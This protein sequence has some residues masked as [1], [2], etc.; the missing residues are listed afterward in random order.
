[1]MYYPSLGGLSF[2]AALPS[3]GS[4]SL[5]VASA[6][7]SVDVAFLSVA[8]RAFLRCYFS[9]RRLVGFPSLQLFLPS[10]SS[11]YPSLRLFFPSLLLF[12][13][14]FGGFPSLQL[15][16]PSVSSLFPSLRGLSVT[17]ALLLSATIN[18]TGTIYKPS[19]K[20]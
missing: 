19:Y 10:V 15:F 4:L 11:L 14:S 7:L 3:V 12:Y 1:M 9:F 17:S 5:S 13:P 8:W 6:V 20:I 18:S 16:L 2:V